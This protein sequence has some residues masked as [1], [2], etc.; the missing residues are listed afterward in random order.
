[1]RTFFLLFLSLLVPAISMAQTVKSPD[2]N[3]SVSFALDNGRPTYSV[4]YKEKAVI[5]PSRLGLQ[6]SEGGAIQYIHTPH[7]SG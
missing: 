7:V 3:V 1:M 4:A 6:L 2:G 5:K